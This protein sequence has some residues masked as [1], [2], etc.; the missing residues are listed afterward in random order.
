MKAR[1]ILLILCFIVVPVAVVQANPGWTDYAT[2]EE[3]VPMARHYY[4]FK[5]PVKE[6]PSG[7]KN[8]Q[9]FYQDY[10]APGSDQM[11]RTLLEALK[12]G[13]GVRVFVTGGC[14]LDG[15]AEISAVSVSR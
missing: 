10:N 11:F 5:L 6:N 13:L 3:L 15:N 2:L 12:S 8:K 7:C 9:V 14:N 4:E 1:V